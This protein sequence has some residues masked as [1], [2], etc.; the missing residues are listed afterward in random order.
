MSAGV[1]ACRNEERDNLR[2]CLT[3]CYLTFG[4]ELL[5]QVIQVL[6]ID[7]NNTNSSWHGQQKIVVCDLLWVMS[8]RGVCICCKVIYLQPVYYE[9]IAEARPYVCRFCHTMSIL[10]Q[11]HRGG[12]RY[13]HN[14]FPMLRYSETFQLHIERFEEYTLLLFWSKAMRIKKNILKCPRKSIFSSYTK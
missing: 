11:S 3:C 6:F 7:I 5:G 9:Y 13:F 12:F 14:I 2:I 10:Q 4:N 1:N 8:L